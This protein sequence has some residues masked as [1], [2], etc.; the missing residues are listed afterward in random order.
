MS[1]LGW[2][3]RIT[4]ISKKMGGPLNFLGAVAVGG[5]VVLRPVEAGVKKVVKIVNKKH[6][7][8]S[9]DKVKE[10]AIY[11]VKKTSQINSKTDVKIGDKI[12]VCGRDKDAVL[13]QIQ[14]DDNN[15]YFVD[16]DLLRKI[17]DYPG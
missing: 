13:I 8:K 4:E 7:A 3:Q 16:I 5:Y 6:N 10:H 17:T 9:K 2:Y 12:E 1:N 14:G 11:T 15:P